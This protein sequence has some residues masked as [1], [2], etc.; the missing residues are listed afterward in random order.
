MRPFLFL[1]LTFSL[2]APL[3]ALPTLTWPT[4]NTAFAEGKPIDAFIQPT[5]SGEP[6]SGTFGC[7]RNSGTRP[8]QGID[9]FPLKRDARGEPA[10]PVFAALS[11]TVVYTSSRPSESSLGR[12][13]VLQHT[14]G[15]LT[16]ST[17]YAHLARIDVKPGDVIK[18][19]DTIALMGH[20]A[21]DGIP[22]DRAHL[23][24]EMNLRLSDDFQTWFLRQKFSTPNIHGNFN[25]FNFSRWD[26]LEFFRANAQNP[27]LTVNDFLRA[28]PTCVTAIVRTRSIPGFIRRNPALLSA[29]IPATGVLGWQIEFTPNG[30]PKLWTPLTTAPRTK[31]LL[32]QG[33]A[34]QLSCFHLRSSKHRPGQTMKWTLELLFGGRY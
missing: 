16:F 14:E 17:L 30:L 6:L 1:C 24:F 29:P 11:G 22:V 25:G 33:T 5:A 12:Y 20:S 18:P 31:L 13:I 23:H 4:P 2:V 3:H 32:T 9:L 21:S 7:V 15:G 19:G 10:D 34:P 27:A 28:Q 8:H 26:P